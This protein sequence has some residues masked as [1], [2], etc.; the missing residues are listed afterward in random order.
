MRGWAVGMVHT[1]LGRVGLYHIRAVR[2]SD[3]ESGQANTC[4][5]RRMCADQSRVWP[6][7]IQAMYCVREECLSRPGF[8]NT[9]LTP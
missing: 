9:Q 7:G 2:G 4:L 3:R 6:S 8:L 1:Q 5:S